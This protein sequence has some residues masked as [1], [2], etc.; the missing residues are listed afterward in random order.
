MESELLQ[1]EPFLFEETLQ[2]DY[3]SSDRYNPLNLRP[4]HEGL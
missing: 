4:L 3:H 1:Y 2:P